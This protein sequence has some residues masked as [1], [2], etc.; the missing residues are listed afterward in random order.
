[1]LAQIHKER[2]K[3]MPLPDVETVLAQL[4]RMG[5]TVP[6]PTEGRVTVDGYGD[7]PELSESLLALI[8]S[9]QKRAGTSLLWT[10]EAE[11]DTVP[12]V[13]DIA[14]V[15]NHL[16]QPALICRNMQ[17]DTVPYNQVTAQYAA[18]EGEGDGSLAYWR[19]AHWD[20]FTRECQR[21]GREP[22]ETM[23]VVCTV[24]ELL[25]VVA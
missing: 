22:V 23:P 25:T 9:G 10:I 18:I 11:N 4:T 3:M 14:L 17:V 6:A 2:N 8:R 20:F 21:I 7:S 5:I 1:M 15:V 16:N 12:Q 13:G 19:E 24:F